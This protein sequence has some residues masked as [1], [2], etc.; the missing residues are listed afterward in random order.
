LERNFTSVP[1][2]SVHKKG[3]KVAEQGKILC[4][5]AINSGSVSLSLSEELIV[6]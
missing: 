2:V 5:T 6:T 1:D 3:E 4:D